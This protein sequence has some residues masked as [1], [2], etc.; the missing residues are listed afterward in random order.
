MKMMVFRCTYALGWL[1]SECITC[2]CTEIIIVIFGFVVLFQVFL[3]SKY[4]TWIVLKT[5]TQIP[6]LS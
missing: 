6:L 4:I 2:N 5:D 3:F 1:S